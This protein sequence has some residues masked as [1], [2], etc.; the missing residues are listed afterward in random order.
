M[1][2]WLTY[3]LI[4]LFA[5]LF[6]ASYSIKSKVYIKA[7]C[8]VKTGKKAVYLTFDDGPD[9]EQTPKVLDVLK[10]NSVKAVFF[11]IGK[12]IAGNEAIMK[13]I[14]DEGHLIG[15]HSYC[16]TGNFPILR[17]SKMI[18]DLEQCRQAI[19]EASG[20]ETTLFRPPFGVTNPIVAKAVK[21]LNL[22]TIG[23]TIRTYD[24]N[25]PK[26]EIVLKRIRRNLK[27]GAIILLHDRLPHSDTLLQKVID[28]IRSAGYEIMPLPADAKNYQ[29]I[30][31]TAK[32]TP[33]TN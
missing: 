23:W 30:N 28:E 9:A 32:G 13:R 12:K 19:A 7:I 27:R 22:T 11:C 26:D 14:A 3:I 31:V 17:R 8:R 15:I 6:Y 33:I 1:Q 21:A 4:S 25:M 5:Y 24:T 20:Q 18:A 10:R 2:E 16:H 29:S